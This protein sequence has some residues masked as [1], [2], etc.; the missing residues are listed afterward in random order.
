M[1]FK[2]NLANHL[3]PVLLS[4][5]SIAILIFVFWVVVYFVLYI[6][7]YFMIFGDGKL[8][9]PAIRAS[10]AFQ[11]A[12]SYSDQEFRNKICI[13]ELEFIVTKVYG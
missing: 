6:E 2:S 5:F 11:E 10:R 3:N 1:F 13:E 12:I 7:G 9:I 8:Q 4:K